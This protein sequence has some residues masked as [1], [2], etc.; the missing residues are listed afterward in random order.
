MLGNLLKSFCW[1]ACAL[2]AS[3]KFQ[4]FNFHLKKDGGCCSFVNFL[5]GHGEFIPNSWSQLALCLICLKYLWVKIV[6]LLSVQV[7]KLWLYEKRHM[8]VFGCTFLCCPWLMS[9]SLFCILSNLA[10]HIYK[11][12]MKFQ[13]PLQSL[14]NANQSGS[15]RW[16]VYKAI[17]FPLL[18]FI[19]FTPP[20]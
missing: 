13:S 5:E 9:L 12:M 1:G 2:L 19:D 17:F 20:S 6:T 11:H 16:F 10:D 3:V 7:W 15:N 14:R 18:S 8:H 4:C